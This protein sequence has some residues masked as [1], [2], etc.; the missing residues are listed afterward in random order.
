MILVP[1]WRI[2]LIAAMLLLAGSTTIQG[3]STEAIDFGSQVQPIFAKRCF[4][5][6]GPDKA[7]SGLRLDR[8]ESSFGKLE[9]GKQALHRKILTTV[10]CFAV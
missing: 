9:S 5:C 4:A 2:R 1:Q 3:Q 10:N 7:E 8:K 6:H